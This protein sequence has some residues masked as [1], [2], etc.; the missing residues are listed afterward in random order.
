MPELQKHMVDQRREAGPAR[1]KATATSPS[2][3]AVGI[4]SSP[5]YRAAP[6]SGPRQVLSRHGLI[7]LLNELGNTLVTLRPEADGTLTKVQS[8]S[9][10]SSDFT[11][12]SHTAYLDISRDGRHLYVSNRVTTP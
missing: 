7:Y 5:R 8:V 1:G 10:L 9:T 12:D 6:G 3:R 2:T 4:S 11:D